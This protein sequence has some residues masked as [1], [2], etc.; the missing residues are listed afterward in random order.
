MKQALILFCILTAVVYVMADPDEYAMP[1]IR[2]APTNT[3]TTTVTSET[4]QNGYLEAIVFKFSG[5][6]NV[7]DID[8]D[9]KTTTNRYGVAWTL[10]SEDDVAASKIVYPR[11]TFLSTS[12]ATVTTNTVRY[13]L[14]QQKIQALA[15]DSNVTNRNVEVFIITS[16]TP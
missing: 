11:D 13:P 2:N 16:P 3:T 8:V 15:G 9:V 6:T 12:G 1:I 10:W 7:V 5:A 14:I 4:F